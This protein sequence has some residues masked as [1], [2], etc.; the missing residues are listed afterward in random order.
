V[1]VA[2]HVD[3]ATIRGNERQ[4]IRIAAGLRERGHD[5][6]VSCRG[7]STVQHALE[8]AG[9]RTTGVRPRGDADLWHAARFA[10]WLRR[11]APD[12]LLL[13]S[14]KRAFIGAAAARAAGVPR[15]LFR[16]GAI[17]PLPAGLRGLPDRLGLA[18]WCHGVIV[19]SRAVEEH[20]RSSLPDLPPDR[21]I[22]IL[23]GIEPQPAPPAPLREM[24]GLP[25]GAVIVL[26]VGGAEARKG[27]D[28]IVECAPALDPRVHVVLAG[29][30]PPDRQS[31]L[32]ARARELGVAHR[33]HLLEWRTDVPALLAASDVFVLSS[34][35]EGMSVAMLE[36]MAAGLPVVAADVGGVWDALAARD[37]RPAAGWIVP[38]ED[39]RALGA[40]VDAVVQGLRSDGPEV[41]ARIAEARWRI[42]HWFT[43][44]RMIDA[45]ESALTAEPL[46]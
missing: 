38:P 13:T 39:S 17:Q 34:R 6:V 32:L 27:F 7:G 15:R 20:V 10:A 18:R 33:V 30:G 9:V 14:W 25:P 35:A 46:R 21:L 8:A 16:L 12:A 3:G 41:S 36:A 26:A 19:N 11:E 43:L 22:T 37:G 28:L 44:A 45:Y 1:K 4:T 5:V 40:A 24:L 31:R 29:G 42:D 23:N 2:M